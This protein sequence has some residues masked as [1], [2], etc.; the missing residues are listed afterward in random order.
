MWTIKLLVLCLMASTGCKGAAGGAGLDERCFEKCMTHYGDNT[1]Q[2]VGEFCSVCLDATRG[3]SVS[4]C[5]AE[6]NCIDRV[7]EG[8]KARCR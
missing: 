1:F 8:C 6:Q 4:G 2:L 3:Q 5:M 7:T